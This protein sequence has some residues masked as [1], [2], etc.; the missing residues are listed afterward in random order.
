VL[1]QLLAGDI[2]TPDDDGRAPSSM[3]P[4]G[5]ERAPGGAAPNVDDS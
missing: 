3:A 5:D 2:T 1:A 4:G